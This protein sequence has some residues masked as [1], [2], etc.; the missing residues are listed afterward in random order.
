MKQ[1]FNTARLGLAIGA[2]ILTTSAANAVITVTN[3]T[4]ALALANA[5]TAG[6]AGGINVVNATLSG[7]SGAPGASSGTFTTNGNNYG[8]TGAGGAVLSTGSADDY[9]SG[10]NTSGAFTTNWAAPATPAQNALLSP[11]TG[12]PNHFDVTIL[13]I[14]FT[15]NP[16]TTG[17]TFN[18]VFGSD[19]Y[20]EFQ[21]TTFIDGFML[22]LNGVNIASTVSGPVNINHPGTAIAETELDAV[23]TLPDGSP[24]L[25]FGGPTIAGVNNITFVIADTSD[26]NYDS[27]VYIQSLGIPAPGALALL[28]LAGLA[29][30]RRRRS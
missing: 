12:Q 1:I 20:F 3:N 13:S 24:L 9:S 15:A 7:H 28:G 6:G 27:T 23:S 25:F 2:M 30:S 11:I 17:V 29:G 26:G 19:E 21:G 8:L 16:G 14:D 5:I 10:A 18:T 22:I 4:N